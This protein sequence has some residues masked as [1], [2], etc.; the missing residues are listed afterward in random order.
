M[1]ENQPLAP[2]PGIVSFPEGLPGFENHTQFVLLVDDEL[3]PLF[4]LASLGEPR[5]TLPVV[6]IQQLQR[7]YSLEVPEPDCRLLG[8]N[9]EPE[10][11]R[12]ILC[13]AV[14]NL[15]DGTRAA[16]ANLFAPIVVNP[17]NW[18]A[19]QIIQFNSMYSTAFEV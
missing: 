1:P 5:I 19:K 13:V 8:L 2:T 16:T 12:N 6:P 3:G 14:V 11:G 7:D 17:E 18:T 4:F 9:G 15:G 10:V